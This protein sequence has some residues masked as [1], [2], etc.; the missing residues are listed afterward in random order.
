MRQKVQKSVKNKII[1]MTRKG[2]RLAPQQQHFEN[3]ALQI[4]LSIQCF[5]VRYFPDGGASTVS[6]GLGPQIG[7]MSAADSTC[8][9]SQHNRKSNDDIEFFQ[10]SEYDSAC[11]LLILGAE[12][13][14]SRNYM[15][16]DNVSLVLVWQLAA[17]HN[18]SDC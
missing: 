14:F 12:L 5:S 16:Y 4:T 3:K 15:L 17:G 7:L 13:T 18:I 11:C 6:A 1:A 9:H 10:M 8:F 2:Y